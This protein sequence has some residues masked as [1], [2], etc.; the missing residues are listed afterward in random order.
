MAV[1]NINVSAGIG[2]CFFRRDNPNFYKLFIG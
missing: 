1:K 2:F